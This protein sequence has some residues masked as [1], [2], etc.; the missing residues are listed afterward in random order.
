ML[1]FFFLKKVYVISWCNTIDI[2]L[3]W[4][5]EEYVITDEI[6]DYKKSYK[7]VI[8]NPKFCIITKKYTTEVSEYRRGRISE[9]NIFASTS[10]KLYYVDMLRYNRNKKLNDLC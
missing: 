4:S 3:T 7:P 9:Y 8:E 6:I 2:A 10:T 5:K 1:K